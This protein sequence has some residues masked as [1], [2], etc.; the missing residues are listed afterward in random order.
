MEEMKSRLYLILSLLIIFCLSSC[1]SNPK[2][3]G[4]T[5]DLYKEKKQSQK[6]LLFEDWKYKGFGQPLPLWFEAAY[7]GDVE[8]VRKQI[9]IPENH[10]IE[11][12]TA[13]GVNSDQANKS[14]WQK[15]F[16][17]AELFE[18]YDSTWVLLGEK[19]AVAKNNSYPYYAAAVILIDNKEE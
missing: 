14:L 19:E 2:P 1:A 12:V 18:L 11:I 17:K 4:D 16:V 15:L 10:K 5:N 3:A 13:Q 7:K 6:R 9:S 8:A